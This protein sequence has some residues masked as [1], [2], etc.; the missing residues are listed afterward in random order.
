MHIQIF[1]HVYM[2]VEKY[3]NMRISSYRG[4]VCVH[5]NIALHM[6]MCVYVGILY[7]YMCI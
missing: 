5:R 3:L 1:T 4:G 7:M 6:D 2:K